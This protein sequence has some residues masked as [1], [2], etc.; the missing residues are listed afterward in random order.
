MGNGFALTAKTSLGHL[1]V[2]GNSRSRQRENRG[3]SLLVV[4][5]RTSGLRLLLM[6][7]IRKVRGLVDLVDDF[8]L[9]NWWF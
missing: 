3:G 2:P 1:W 4:E 8:K 7:A 6:R 9:I 5:L